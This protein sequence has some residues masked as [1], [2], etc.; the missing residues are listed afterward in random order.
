MTPLPFRL[1]RTILIAASRETV[2]GFFTNDARWAS[3]WGTGSTIDARPGGKV[4]IRYPGGIEVSGEVVEAVAPD[5][6]AFTYGFV[7]GQPIAVGA[8]LVTIRLEAVEDGTLLHLA[9]EFADEKVRDE[10]V[11]GWRYQLS[12]FGNVVADRLH[13]GAATVVDDWFRAW[14]EPDADA[15]SR[16]LA[17]IAVPGVRFRDRHS[18]IDGLADL[19]DQLGAYQRFMPGMRLERRGDVRHCQGMLLVEWTALGP[20]GQPRGSGTNVFVLD[21][22]GRI[23]AVTGFWAPKA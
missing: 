16:S 1:D 7:S 18:L 21:A 2:F 10:H 8:S 13:A 6:I 15:R 11:Q 3:W 17:A 23:A 4:L 19:T 5:H 14:S 12:V 20:D 22:G 9:H